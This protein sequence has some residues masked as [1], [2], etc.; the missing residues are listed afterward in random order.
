M[1]SSTEPTQRF[2]GR[3]VVVAGAAS[4]IG[5]VTAE[6]LVAEGAEVIAVDIDAAGLDVLSAV[7]GAITPVVGDLTNATHIEQIIQVVGSDVDGVVSVAGIHDGWLPP[8]E[9]D[10]ETWQRVFALN[11]EA[12]MRLTRALLPAMIAR[13]RGSFVYISS[14]AGLR[15]SL[16]GA[17]YT[18]SKNA[19]Q[20]FAKSV[21]FYYGRA[22]V[23]SNCVAPGGVTTDM[24]TRYRSEYARE[25]TVPRLKPE[26]RPAAVAPSVIVRP[27]LW[28]LSDEAAHINGV[29]LPADAGWSVI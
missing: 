2:F 20:G 22:G 5:K 13:G 10:D 17:A 4:G 16:G 18:A 23:R 29:V 12:P 9:I 3:R 28:L 15:A 7:S 25:M 14:E 21:A 26:L 24:D 6:R 19:L 11:V 1:S 27:I 8:A